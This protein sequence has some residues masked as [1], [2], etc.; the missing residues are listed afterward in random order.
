MMMILMQ[1]T[2][3]ITLTISHRRCDYYELVMNMIGDGAR[4]HDDDGKTIYTD[5]SDPG[6]GSFFTNTS[7]T[8]DTLPGKAVSVIYLSIILTCC[9][10]LRIGGSGVFVWK[11]MTVGVCVGGGGRVGGGGEGVFSRDCYNAVF[12]G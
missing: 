9:L 6:S 12:S 11:W 2:A 4:R 8:G 3:I 5:T 10:K 7:D 1:K